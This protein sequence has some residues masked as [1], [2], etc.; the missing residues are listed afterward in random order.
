MIGASMGTLCV[1]DRTEWRPV[2]SAER[3]CVHCDSGQ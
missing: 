1:P 3:V 2:I